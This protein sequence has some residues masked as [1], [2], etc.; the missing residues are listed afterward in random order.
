M[1][2]KHF[3]QLLEEYNHLISQKQ[4]NL[5]LCDQNRLIE[6]KKIISEELLRKI[7]KTNFDIAGEETSYNRDHLTL[8]HMYRGREHL[9]Q[10]MKIVE[11]EEP[12]DTEAT[13]RPT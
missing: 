11:N 1:K 13:Y 12:V 10:L 3:E 7:R 6:V 2:Q 5:L 9:N 8:M 4:F